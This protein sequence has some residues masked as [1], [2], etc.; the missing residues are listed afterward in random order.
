MGTWYV[1][2]DLAPD[3][4][5]VL[6]GLPSRKLMWIMARERR[7]PAAEYQRLLDVAKA[8]GFPVDEVRKVPQRRTDLGQPGFE[9]P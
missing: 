6:I 2:V 7:L 3:Y 8:E 1:I 4:R 9:Q 5:S